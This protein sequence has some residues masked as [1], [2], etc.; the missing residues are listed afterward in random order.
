MTSGPIGDVEFLRAE[1]LE[2]NSNTA[3]KE[4]ILAD[5][6]PV[7]TASFLFLNTFFVEC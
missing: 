3:L 6:E 2:L 1:A 4:A 7:S 5:I